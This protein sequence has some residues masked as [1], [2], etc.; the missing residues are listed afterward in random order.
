[1]RA[2]PEV[3]LAH[4]SPESSLLFKSDQVIRENPAT[5]TSAEV[6]LKVSKVSKY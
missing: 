3:K 2:D 5:E 1:V 6:C 4:F